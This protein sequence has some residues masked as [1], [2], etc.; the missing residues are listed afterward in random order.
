MQ[1]QNFV[2]QYH[3]NVSSGSTV[4]NGVEGM[5]QVH[6]SMK[7]LSPGQI[8]EGSVVSVKNDQVVLNLSNGQNVTARMEGDVSLLLGQSVFFEVKNNVDGKIEISPLQTQLSNNP[9]L[10][11]ALDQAGLPHSSRNLEMVQTMMKEELPIDVKSL[12][13]MARSIALNPNSSVDTLVTMNR[14]QIPTSPEMISQF[15]N[16]MS[17]Q[18]EILTAVDQLS[19]QISTA[20]QDGSIP[21]DSLLDFSKQLLQVVSGDEQ[22]TN[23]TSLEQDIQAN[24]ELSPQSSSNQVADRLSENG[25]IRT[26]EKT[27]SDTVDTRALNENIS[28]EIEIRDGDTLRNQTVSNDGV[29]KGLAS[30]NSSTISSIL[31]EKISQLSSE[32]KENGFLA[33]HSEYRDENGNLKAES[34]NT[35]FLRDVLNHLFHLGENQEQASTRFLR[36]DA[37]RSLLQSVLKEKMS[38]TP[39]DL[40][41]SDSKNQI[42]DLY[43]RLNKQMD[44]IQQLAK[45]YAGEENPVSNV[46]RNIQ[47]NVSFMNH[48]NQN[49]SYV[50]IPLQLSG[51]NATGDL[52]VYRNHKGAKKG[53]NEELTAFLH[54]DLE[55]LGSTDVSVRLKNKEVSTSF[56]FDNDD[57]FHLVLAH[58]DELQEKLRAKGY[59]SEI[60]VNRGNEDSKVNFI[61]QVVDKELPKT[62]NLQRYSFDVRA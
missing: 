5:N 21:K 7:Q 14:L 45:N 25:M 2:N 31:G 58:I 12:T 51:Q 16:Y 33:S 17:D 56:Y 24:N 62:G 30:S 13:D 15:E 40:Q 32:L 9:T 48:L 22:G 35:D 49:Y 20:I 26:E 52:Y 23:S 39:E 61:T 38:L 18:H 10:L 57:S 4:S 41:K 53:E 59:N 19:D 44:S 6:D 54:F 28:S 55:H 27:L 47:D 37:F 60:S 11:N 42:K 3:N 1:I 50:Q 34:P 29:Q 8:F 36:G 43:E 46:A